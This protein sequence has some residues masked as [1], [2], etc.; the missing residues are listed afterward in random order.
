MPEES[1]NL[2]DVEFL[3]HGSSAAG[4]FTNFSV[5]NFTSS[6]MQARASA[7]KNSE[8]SKSCTRLGID[9]GEV[10]MAQV[11]DGA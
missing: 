9:A 5:R 4:S 1:R 11:E 7:K 3:F 8:D 10:V 2:S 6:S